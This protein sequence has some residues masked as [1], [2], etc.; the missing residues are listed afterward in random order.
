MDDK[1]LLVDIHLLESRVHHALRNIPKSKAALTA[2]RTAANA[3]YVPP[4]A[5]AEIDC[6]SG[7][8][9]A[10][11]KDYKTA[12]SYFYEGFEQY[13]SV[14]EKNAGPVLKYMLLCKIMSGNAD[15]VA[16]IVNTKAGLKYSNSG[17]DAMLAI[18]EAYKNRS[19]KEFQAA[20]H[21]YSEDLT[22]DIIVHNH[23]KSLYDKML[24][25]NICRLIEPYSCV[26][27]DFVANKLNLPVDVVEAKMSQCILDKVIYATLDQGSGSLIIYENAEIDQSYKACLE[28]FGTLMNVVQS[29]HQRSNKL[30]S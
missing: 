4:N 14:D 5:Q 27:I 24:E 29:L 18:A 11:E 20:L 26:Q 28:T 9:H 10:E 25:Q 12:Y 22:Q 6:Q 7:T 16:S 13:S 19:L 21:K 17:V 8:L 30:V 1:L 23:L 15:D 2:A 3:I